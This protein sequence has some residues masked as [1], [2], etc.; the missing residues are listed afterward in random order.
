ML[1]NWWDV[2]L[3]GKV[4]RDFD[5]GAELTAVDVFHDVSI[6]SRPVVANLDRVSCLL[7]AKM[8]VAVVVCIANAAPKLGRGNHNAIRNPWDAAEENAV[9]Y[10]EKL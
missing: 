1:T 2:R 6:H 8:S 9:P 7:N 10:E 4:L 3:P 5:E